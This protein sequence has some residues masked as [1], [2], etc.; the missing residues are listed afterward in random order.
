M[1]TP[2]GPDGMRLE[3][4]APATEGYYRLHCS[5]KVVKK[6]GVTLEEIVVVDNPA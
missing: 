6:P 3:L 5:I 2:T 1:R 4:T